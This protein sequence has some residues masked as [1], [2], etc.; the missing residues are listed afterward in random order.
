M[1]NGKQ[2]SIIVVHR[3]I[4]NELMHMSNDCINSIK[5]HTYNEYELICI[6]NDSK[7]EYSNALSISCNT[8][9]RNAKNLGNTYAWDQG[10]MLA[11]NDY[12]ILIDN[13]V[14][15]DKHWD[16]EMIEKLSDTVGITFPYS[17]IGSE[18]G[19][20]S[21]RGRRD[22]FCFAFT[23]DIY[24]QAGPFLQDQPFKLGYY[25]DDNFEAYVQFKLGL[26]LVSCPSSQVWHKGQGTT[27]KMWD[28]KIETGIK[29]NKAWYESKW[30]K[31]PFIEK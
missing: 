30:D 6:D 12:I 24:K 3:I 4:D 1:D 31:F 15:V 22:G 16:K 19:G 2:I 28:E 9:L 23:K 29:A 18:I 14:K 27:K 26:K 20:Q 21:Y 8:Y 10:I 17:I 5:K 13:D 25:E 11:K 7:P